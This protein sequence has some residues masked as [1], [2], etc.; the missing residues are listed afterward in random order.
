MN[1]TRSAYLEICGEIPNE[2]VRSE[3]KAKVSQVED[4][5]QNLE[6]E[7]DGKLQL[8]MKGAGA[9]VQAA[10]LKRWL[11]EK[12]EQLSGG[13]PSQVD[14]KETD[15]KQLMGQ[16]QK[17]RQIQEELASKQQELQSVQLDT[18]D[19]GALSQ[20][21][22]S[23]QHAVEARQEQL[24]KL[25]SQH[26][27]LAE[28]I[29]LEAWILAKKAE[30][31][32]PLASQGHFLRHPDQLDG[33]VN[34]LRATV[35]E[36]D[37]NVVAVNRIKTSIKDAHEKSEL[38]TAQ[39]E[40]A[41]QQA[42]SL[43]G[44]LRDLV[45]HANSRI[46]QAGDV[47][48]C[49]TSA[50]KSI[51]AFRSA[52][53]DAE[54][55]W[56]EVQQ[57]SLSGVS[58]RGDHGKDGG[59][60]NPVS[61]EEL[62]Q[63]QADLINLLDESASVHPSDKPPSIAAELSAT[64]GRLDSALK[65]AGDADAP[66]S[67][68]SLLKDITETRRRIESIIQSLNKDLGSAATGDL[69]VGLVKQLNA[70]SKQVRAAQDQLV[71]YPA[72]SPGLDPRT[73]RERTS[74][75]SEINSTLVE[76]KQISDQLRSQLQTHIKQNGE[77]PCA[78][79]LLLKIQTLD[80]A[81]DKLQKQT[82]QLRS[83]LDNRISKTEQL[84]TLRR[85][86]AASINQARQISL[87]QSPKSKHPSE[88]G[89][90]A[91]LVEQMAVNLRDFQ[92]VASELSDEAP[93]DLPQRQ[94]NSEIKAAA[95]AVEEI[96]ANLGQTGEVSQQFSDSHL[97][98]VENGISRLRTVLD[99]VRSDFTMLCGL[100]PADIDYVS[101][102]DNYRLLAARC[103]A[104]TTSLEYLDALLQ[105]VQ[106]DS[107]AR[108][109]E[110]LSRS[111]SKLASDYK[112][113]IAQI[114]T[115][116]S[117]TADAE[118]EQ[119]DLLDRIQAAVSWMKDARR[120]F[121]QYPREVEP[122]TSEDPQ[123]LADVRAE[124]RDMRALHKDIDAHRAPI[125]ELRDDV[126]V[127]VNS[128]RVLD[129]EQI[130]L[131]FTQLNT[132]FEELRSDVRQRLDA[133]QTALPTVQRLASSL[134][135]LRM[136]LP[137]AESRLQQ[138]RESTESMEE[139]RSAVD[140][141]EA[142]AT[143]VLIPQSQS[144]RNCWERLQQMC[145]PPHLLSLT[146][147]QNGESTVETDATGSHG[148]DEI[149]RELDRCAKF[150]ADLSAFAENVNSTKHQSTEKLAE[151][152]R[153][154]KWLR[155]AIRR[156]DVKVSDTPTRSQG[157]PQE[158]EKKF[159]NLDDP[160]VR[161]AM[162]KSDE[163]TTLSQYP[164]FVILPADVDS[165]DHLRDR[166]TH[167]RKMW[168]EKHARLSDVLSETQSLLQTYGLRMGGEA[169]LLGV[170]KSAALPGADKLSRH[171]V[172]LVDLVAQRSAQLD[173]C[174]SQ[175]EAKLEETYPLATSYHND[176][177]ELKEWLSA[178]EAKLGDL[179]V[180][181][182]PKNEN[183]N[184]LDHQKLLYNN[185]KALDEEAE[186][187]R[188]VLD[189]IVRISGPFAQLIAQ[190][191]ASAIHE[192]TKAITDRYQ[193]LS[194]IIKNRLSSLGADLK[195]SD[196]IVEKFNK[197][198][199]LF[200]NVA[201]QA[202]HLGLP[203]KPTSTLA[204]PHATPV[205]LPEPAAPT[206]PPAAIQ[207]E[208]MIGRIRP[209][210]SVQPEQ[211][212]EQL[213]ETSMLIEALD[214]SLPELQALTNC[215]G[216]QL[217]PKLVAQKDGHPKVLP[218]VDPFAAD[219]DRVAE[220]QRTMLQN[221]EKLQT[222]WLDL[223]TQL[224]TRVDQLKSA[225]RTSSNEFWPTVTDLQAAFGQAREHLC[226]IAC[227]CMSR[228]SSSVSRK[229]PLDPATYPEQRKELNKLVERL[230]ELN[231]RLTKCEEFGSHLIELISGVGFSLRRE[232]EQAIRSEVS[233]NLEELH[234]IYKSL[235]TDCQELSNYIDKKET[236]AKSFKE[237]LV[238]FTGWLSEQEVIWDHF[239]P[240]ANTGLAV[241]AQLEEVVAWNNSL[242]EKHA[243]LEA[244]NWN[245][246]QLTS[247][248]VG[249]LAFMDTVDTPATL[250]IPPSSLQADLAGCNRRWEALLDSSNQRRHKLQTALL[251]LG[252]FEKAVNAL[253]SWIRNT[254]MNLDRV[255]IR[256]GSIRELE[257]QMSRVKII[258]SSIN[259]HQ[260][261]ISRIQ[262]QA[263]KQFGPIDQLP[264]EDQAQS[265]KISQFR[266]ANKLLGELN[267]SWERLRK[268]VRDKQNLLEEAL[269][270]AFA[271]QGEFDALVRKCR[272]LEHRMPS[273]GSRI[274]GGL[275]DTAREQLRRF[276]EIYEGLVKI[277]NGISELRRRFA[278][279]LVCDNSS[280]EPS[281]GRLTKALDNFTDY[282]SQLLHRAA[283]I[284]DQLKSGLSEVEK[285]HS[286]LAE[287]VQ[288][289]T[290]T[291][292]VV[293]V[294]KPVS[295]I[296]A[297]LG[298][299]ILDHTEIRKD[300]A[301]HRDPL[302]RLDRMGAHVQCSAQKNDVVLV[303]NLL[304]SI[305]NRWEQL[306]SR[307]AERTHQLN[308][309]LKEAETFLNNW[310]LL[311]DWL[312]E[313]LTCLE[314]QRGQIATRP[315]KISHQLATHR[316]FQ[317]QLSTRT[318][319]YDA[320]RRYARKMRDRAPACD[321]AE[322][323][324]MVNEL[325]HL[326]Q[327]LC[328]NSLDRQ[329]ALEQALLSA[330]MYKEAVNSL[331]DWLSRVEPEL[332]DHQVG[333]YGD[334]ETV[335]QLLEVH[336][337]FSIELADRAKW[338]GTVREAAAELTS[339][340]TSD[341]A[342]SR[343]EV[344]AIGAQLN[345]LNGAWERVQI[346][347]QKRGE[348]L[349]EAMKLAVQFQEMCRSLM[350]YFAG[351]EHVIRRLAALPTYDDVL[352]EERQ[353]ED[354]KEPADETPAASEINKEHAKSSKSVSQQQPPSD[355]ASAIEAHSHTHDNL[356][357]QAERVQATLQLGHQLLAQAHPDAVP[358]L[359]QWIHTIQGRWNDLTSWSNQRGER[360]K[361]ALEEQQ[362]R[363][364]LLEQLMDWI[365]ATQ[366]Q[367]D[368]EPTLTVTSKISQ[369]P[370]VEKTP[371]FAEG[372]EATDA[373]VTDT[374]KGSTGPDEK[375]LT[376]QSVPILRTVAID[377]VTEP[378]IIER[379]LEQHTDLEVEAERRK[380]DYENII[381]HARRKS[382]SKP[383]NAAAGNTPRGRR[384]V[385]QPRV[386]TGRPGS[387]RQIRPPSVLARPEV[388]E[389]RFV[390][391]PVNKLYNRWTALQKALAA[392]RAKLEDRMTYLTEVEKMKNFEFESWRSR[393]VA[394]LNLNKARVID[395]FHRKD[396]D[397]DG[398]L[399]RAE[400]VDGILE[401]KFQ[402]SRM[403]LE[404]VAD[405]FDA[406]QDGYIDYRECLNA[407][408]AGYVAS[409]TGYTSVSSSLS[410][411]GPTDDEAINDEV[412][413]QIGLCTCH[414]TYQ[415]CKMTS[416]KYR[417]GDSQ[418][419]CLVRILR[420]A[421]MVRVG[422]GWI[423]LD[424]FLA[425]NDPCRGA[426]Q[427]LSSYTDLAAAV[428]LAPSRRPRRPGTMSTKRRGGT[429][430]TGSVCSNPLRSSATSSVSSAYPA[431]SD[432]ARYL[433]PALIQR[434]VG[435]RTIHGPDQE[436]AFYL[437]MP[438]TRANPTNHMSPS[439]TQSKSG[440]DERPPPSKTPLKKR[441][442]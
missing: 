34:R 421:V 194:R 387:G 195:E 409:N 124:L 250:T 4:E 17:I 192:E 150:L 197:M 253:L 161:Q 388:E 143:T 95:A 114:G 336:Q 33:S 170:T 398:R 348:K 379:L 10:E 268:S 115:H 266:Q 28:L 356:M 413:R 225:H 164:S 113:L 204:R 83:G 142:E 351:A 198:S 313:Q 81:V 330:G 200:T 139:K 144:L 53:D 133:L 41:M 138:A 87:P 256:R 261:A 103:D 219:A 273:P 40:S 428:G 126:S 440:Q 301:N 146:P 246:S 151:L 42:D 125:G 116:L 433:R 157:K 425:K 112:K 31:S 216:A 51:K 386:G 360:L 23:L 405:I 137:A 316:E 242:L 58:E 416:N 340:A 381:N 403:E 392:R 372:A 402:T 176:V 303:K 61:T 378:E 265:G 391:P 29:K 439:P 241:L 94:L 30:I 332:T 69:I 357:E 426:C 129:S 185:V 182:E 404:A 422:G 276:M 218:V 228:Q 44:Q 244:L 280:T 350:D 213:T 101:R 46:N 349:Q 212:A 109:K 43:L 19:S 233:M 284:R 306:L 98:Q 210:V 93:K 424:E 281:A 430:G 25:I 275:P 263:K 171:L 100:S 299:M 438:N 385:T 154:S 224:Q 62:S 183:G 223:K 375:E 55:R 442:K 429:T 78:S 75:L 431:S 235:V 177:A 119:K 77:I 418:K 441:K 352:Q 155:L 178:K 258:H 86:L 7:L 85:N 291:E 203:L 358:R 319:A 283:A 412:R 202:S 201:E 374:A 96:T 369:Q 231:S 327:A 66:H 196:E 141:L 167:F 260:L 377:E 346:L 435:L 295:R 108:S 165:L 18:T 136:R 110:E 35:F 122:K 271:F 294:Q 267:N 99:E 106:S 45:E 417:F 159:M 376:T 168:G 57:K 193:D 36:S 353:R 396:N 234:A 383:S 117:Q 208:T 105:S 345:Y 214:Q 342:E 148:G 16:M 364:V 397:H 63:L 262:E 255:P 88:L 215:L 324:D 237:E 423:T 153:E 230:D 71:A 80:E 49:Y 257:A 243:D 76:C 191:E 186:K 371:V 14:P 13:A 121:D 190:T 226:L 389:S 131:K 367:L 354:R 70:V 152:D 259:S 328:T 9:Q 337:S 329:R 343:A 338:I 274:M 302:L 90:R 220:L 370:D 245:A 180:G 264:S 211:L 147:S 393:Y 6:K 247:T 123:L 104:R 361:S 249:E 15:F 160:T 309:G 5:I 22:Q 296:V 38:S 209:M 206:I 359:R 297:R 334:V 27:I 132:S 286:E 39:R 59:A 207:G 432:A 407:L 395:L 390:S 410:H 347:A 240:V 300:I 172:T 156:F 269:R 285:F 127:L 173:S 135:A 272:H 399:T 79:D 64:M 344:N 434:H 229:D 91:V 437:V 175:A 270:E 382:L 307:S 317:R 320:I 184:E 314:E 318:V 102:R 8:A 308:V 289:L 130:Q 287:M 107:Q 365:G 406:N 187:Y 32:Q 408:R 189:R 341:Q 278:S 56:I 158:E 322:L 292:R 227:G 239:D 419:L 339:N 373:N 310:T 315:E 50:L 304:A 37:A 414:H 415:I 1:E 323:D 145:L 169:T 394:W 222:D 366:L 12:N 362:K 305:H 282:H 236:A 221:A 279:L 128:G 3:L 400:F 368:R 384:K 298:Q 118:R 11:S 181:S 251:A 293:A 238:K 277:G 179:T 420:S 47:K 82:G 92:K 163:A 248:D 321:H 20:Q 290:Q 288:W 199:D 331:V 84:D 67:M 74:S 363:R 205:D 65:A 188:T 252:E 89:E 140:Q 333:C 134:T 411:L 120:K 355:L 72:K 60:E 174:L 325:K 326:W 111:L 68:H 2:T 312:R 54:T 52:A 380:Q 73:L 427:R 48:K 232:E 436:N 149:K 26:P 335:E 311:T 24:D 97:K 162:E 401:M 166:L 217:E 254:Q 21:M